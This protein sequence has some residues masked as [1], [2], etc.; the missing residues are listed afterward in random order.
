MK[1]STKSQK[2]AAPQAPSLEKNTVEPVTAK[3][4]VAPRKVPTPKKSAPAAGVPPA[5]APAAPA[6]APAPAAVAPAKPA[7][8]LSA[9]QGNHATTIVAQRD[10]GFGNQLY[11]RGE[12]PGLSWEK[13]KLMSCVA[14]DRWELRLEGASKEVVFKF[15]LNDTT[16]SAGED[17]IVAPGATTVVSPSF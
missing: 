14:D 10:V 16:W 12:G 13:G 11:V 7:P 17:F 2:P 3:K 5:P 15:V 8:A 1:K 4:T 6:P 9:S